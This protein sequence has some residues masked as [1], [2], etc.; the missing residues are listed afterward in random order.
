MFY[1]RGQYFGSYIKKHC[2]FFLFIFESY[3]VKSMPKPLIMM[4]F[5]MKIN[6]NS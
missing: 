6:L 1:N 2:N 4:K 3:N 5:M